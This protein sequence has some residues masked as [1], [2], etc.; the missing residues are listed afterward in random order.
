MAKVTNAFD[1][2]TATSDRESLSDVIYNISPSTTPFM[3]SIGKSNVKNVQFDWQTEALPTAS[4]TGELEGFELSRSASTA[5]VRESNI[6]QISS[7]DATVTGSQQA[8]DPAGKRSEMAHQL[9][10][11]AKALKRDMET[12]LCSKVAKNAGN[13]TTARQTGGFETWT[14]TNV[15]RGTNGAGAGNGAAPTDGTQRAFTETILKSVQ[16]SAF[17]NGGEPSMLIVGPHVKGVVSGFTGR[18][19]A[20]Q[21]IDAQTIEASVAIYSG[22]F[23][24]LKVVPSNFSRS[25][26]ALFV[27]P[28]YA[29]VA[30][31]RDFETVDISTIGDAE[32]KMLVVEFGLEVSNEKAHGIAAD[33]STS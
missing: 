11:M 30:Y 6:C 29:K 28:D 5:T 26:S 16:Q 20:R 13:A 25:R 12:A 9:A 15:S 31:L 23:G 4:G 3:S 1:T 32:T 19:Q 10:I 17:T 7:R 8:S 33:L 22:D 18:S 21:N 24:E 2:Y 14:E 27:D